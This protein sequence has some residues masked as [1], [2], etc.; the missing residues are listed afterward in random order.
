M[1]W[2]KKCQNF[3]INVVFFLKIEKHTW[4]YDF[5]YVYLKS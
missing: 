4:R 5:T 2:A 1:K 3:N